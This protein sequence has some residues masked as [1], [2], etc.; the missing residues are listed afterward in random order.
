MAKFEITTTG[1]VERTY[2]VE[3]EDED[4]AK[5]RLRIYI[6]DSDA[7]KP[8]VVTKQAKEV[9]S[10]PE[11]IKDVGTASDDSPEEPSGT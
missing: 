4:Q 8:G 3:A 9:N 10:T 2:V 1:Q 7:V 11:R 6:G 5:K